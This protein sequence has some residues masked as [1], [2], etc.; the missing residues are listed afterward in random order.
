M[1][2]SVTDVTAISGLFR[3]KHLYLTFDL[4]SEGSEIRMHK[5]QDLTLPYRRCFF[6]FMGQW[7]T[8]TRAAS[9]RTSSPNKAGA[10]CR[11]FTF[12]LE[13]TYHLWYFGT[14]CFPSRS[15]SARPW[16]ERQKSLS[17]NFRN[18]RH[19][20]SFCREFGMEIVGLSVERFTGLV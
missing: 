14:E 1:N 19:W 12:S 11:C 8:L 17:K 16:N 7:C 5:L 13:V 15:S 18:W 2:G 20:S 9:T 3:T 4:H 6:F 10:C